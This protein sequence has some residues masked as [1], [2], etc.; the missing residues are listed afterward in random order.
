MTGAQGPTGAL[1]SGSR[2]SYR[3]SWSH[4]C[5]GANRY[6]RCSRTNWALLRLFMGSSW[7]KFNNPKND[8]GVLIKHSYNGNNVIELS[9]NGIRVNA[10]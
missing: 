2:W 9:E 6:N 1:G 7:F 3:S 5:S 4:G 8:K 10:L